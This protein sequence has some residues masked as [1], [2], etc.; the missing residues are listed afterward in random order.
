MNM[1]E[2]RHIQKWYADKLVLDD[3]NL[4]VK[5]GE[6]LSVIGPSGA[7]K[8]TLLRCINFLEVPSAGQV[9][10]DGEAIEYKVN[11][12]GYLTYRS[13]VYMSTVRAKV[14]MVFQHFNLWK[15]KTVLENVIEGPMLVKKVPRSEAVEKAEELLHKV[16]L[17]D[18]RGAH[19]GDL[20]G[21]QQ[22]RV[23]IARALA[24]EPVVMLFDE[25][26]SAL[27]P[28]LVNEVLKIMVQLAEE[29][30]TMVVVTHEMGFARDVSHRVVFMEN[31]KIAAEG[32]SYEIFDSDLQPRVT[33]FLQNIR[34]GVAKNR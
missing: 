3:V 33:K 18:K 26:T 25:A 31:G 7:G 14:G 12:A 13:K 2:L 22:Q 23:A 1:I 21:G 34:Y 17:Y 24:M 29:G 16:G 28:E 6:V 20:S 5:K 32:T 15:H 8:S 30:M 19:P 4:S 9:L 10:I 11:R 27:D